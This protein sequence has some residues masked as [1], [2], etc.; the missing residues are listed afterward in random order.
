MSA[1]IVLC[2][3]ELNSEI[4]RQMALDTSA[5]HRRPFR[6]CGGVT[7]DM[8]GPAIPHETKEH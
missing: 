1:I 8:P 5:G 6:A 4:E 2:G 3:A 7:A